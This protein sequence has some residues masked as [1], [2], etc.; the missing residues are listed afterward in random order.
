MLHM[1]MYM[2]LTVYVPSSYLVHMG[3]CILACR[4][5]E[6]CFVLTMKCCGLAGVHLTVTIV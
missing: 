2:W 6:A 5:Y 3:C 1:Y 4:S